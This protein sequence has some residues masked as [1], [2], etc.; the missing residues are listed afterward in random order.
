MVDNMWMN[1]AVSPLRQRVYFDNMAFIFEDNKIFAILNGMKAYGYYHIFQPINILS[2]KNNDAFV[3][4]P[5]DVT[6]LQ[7]YDSPCDIEVEG[8]GSNLPVFYLKYID[9]I[10]DK[11]DAEE[12]VILAIDIVTTLLGGWGIA[13]RLIA[14]G[15]F[16]A[17]RQLTLRSV[18]IGISAAIAELTPAVRANML[19]ILRTVAV[20]TIELALGTASIMHTIVEGNCSIY[21]DCNNTSPAEGQPG[22]EAYQRCQALQKWLFA[23]EILTLSGELIAKTFFKKATREA[24]EVLPSVNPYPNIPNSQYDDLLSK[25]DEIDNLIDEFLEFFNDLPQSIQD[26]LTSLNLSSVKKYA[27]M[28][29]FQNRTDEIA[30]LATD[31]HLIDDWA[32]VAA[33]LAGF[34]KDLKYLRAYRRFTDNPHEVQ[35]ITDFTNGSLTG[36]FDPIGAHGGKNLTN[37]VLRDPNLPAPPGSPPTSILDRKNGHTTYG[38]AYFIRP[39]GSLKRKKLQT[40]WN[41]SWDDVRIQS[42]MALAFKNKK[43]YRLTKST[44]I[45]IPGFSPPP[46]YRTIYRSFLS[47]GTEVEMVIYNFAKDPVTTVAN[48]IETIQTDHIGSFKLILK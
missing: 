39:D 15:V 35:H 23:L 24:R 28:F 5:I 38:N 27:F 32:E 29:D 6:V 7:D 47:D 10:G 22:F 19:R 41:P 40:I 45:N 17:A 48:G 20:P 2:F 31:T 8:R 44:G 34:R 33:E 18:E 4:V 13:R 21:N 46:Q 42:E 36:G 37:G 16:I 9:D 1:Y 25:L 14:E 30:E 26:K 3:N 12:T 11:K 43:L